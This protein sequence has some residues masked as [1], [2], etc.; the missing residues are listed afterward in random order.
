MRGDREDKSEIEHELR[1]GKKSSTGVLRDKTKEEKTDVGAV[2]IIHSGGKRRSRKRRRSTYQ[3][4]AKTQIWEREAKRGLE[5]SAY[6]NRG[7]RI[8]RT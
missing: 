3:R 5:V 1:P 7:E 2:G 8:G 6:L 4:L